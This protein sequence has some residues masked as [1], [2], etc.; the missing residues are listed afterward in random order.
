MRFIGPGICLSHTSLIIEGTNYLSIID[1]GLDSSAGKNAMEQSSI[2]LVFELSANL[3]KPVRNIFISHSHIDHIYNTRIYFEK[4]PDIV[5][6]GHM[7]SP[8]LNRLRKNGVSVIK[9]ESDMKMTIDGI[10]YFLIHTPGHSE[11]R[12]DLSFYIP[13]KR[14]IQVGDLF[15]PQGPKYSLADSVSPLPYF[16]EGNQYLRSLEKIMGF[17]YDVFVTGHG[18]VLD[19][20]SG[21]KGLEQTKMILERIRDLALK[22]TNE[23]IHADDNLI[24]EWIFDTI[25]YE[26]NFDKQKAE[27]RKGDGVKKRTHFKRF[28]FPGIQY[29]VKKARTR[30]KIICHS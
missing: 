5:C 28:D 2:S 13:E 20:T 14:I 9:V 23:N 4:F 25:V 7:N 22:L 26:R 11:P 18:N 29:F 17:D 15:Q 21:K 16:H 10:E 24:C 8:F 1:P 19:G 12:D 30:G 27:K 3:N 6:I